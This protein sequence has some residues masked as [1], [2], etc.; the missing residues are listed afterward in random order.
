MIDSRPQAAGDPGR[1]IVLAGFLLV[2]VAGM[3]MIAWD[4]VRDR[5]AELV[6]IRELWLRPEAH[7][8]QRVAIQGTLRVFLVGT[9][10]QHYAVED[11]RH[12]RV[13]V[14]GVSRAQ[15][16]PLVGRPVDV[17][18]TV[19]ITAE[20]IILID[21]T[22]ISETSRQSVGTVDAPVSR[23]TTTSSLGGLERSGHGS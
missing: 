20:G 2:I 4:R 17:E 18:G 10:I 1:R 15:L 6:A 11:A 7:D 3:G 13:G 9:P 19:H 21:V 23:Y 12:N 22:S 5:P 16:D 14:R 8:G